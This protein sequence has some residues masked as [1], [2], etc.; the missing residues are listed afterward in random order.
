MTREGFFQNLKIKNIKQINKIVQF[1][2]HKIEV[3]GSNEINS[4]KKNIFSFFLFVFLKYFFLFIHF[5][6]F[7]IN[8]LKVVIIKEVKTIGID[9]GRI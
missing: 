1:I 9:M 4:L 8:S 7:N 5:V 6:S 3:L 2:S